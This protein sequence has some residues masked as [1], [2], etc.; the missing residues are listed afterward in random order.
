MM[1]FFFQS[2]D[3]ESII[4]MYKTENEQTSNNGIKNDRILRSQ[5]PKEPSKKDLSGI[6]E[7][8]NKRRE[9]HIEK[10]ENENAISDVPDVQQIYLEPIDTNSSAVYQ[11]VESSN[12]VVEA[13]DLMKAQVSI[14]FIDKFN[15]LYL[16]YK[17]IFKV[18]LF[19]NYFII[20]VHFQSN[21]FRNMV[22]FV[23]R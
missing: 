12:V 19:P 20:I 8:L 4:H 7:M 11:T 1:V 18:T 21:D 10:Q 17:Y 23:L 2:S 5:V 22:C 15:S 3:R 9:E 6:I 13:I 14:I 16:L